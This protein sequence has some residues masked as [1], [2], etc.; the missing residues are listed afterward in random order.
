MT[1]LALISAHRV[2][3]LHK[4]KINNIESLPSQIN[5]KIPDLIKTSKAGINQPMLCIPFFSEKPEICPA[6]TLLCYI[7]RT[8]PLRKTDNLLISFK[9]PHNIITT[10]SI[11]RWIKATLKDCGIDDS[12]FTAHNTRHASTSKAHQL[13]VN[14][15]VIRKTAGW[16]GTSATFGKFY[17]R[18]IINND[19]QITLA[20]AILNNN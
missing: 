2:Q 10:Q 18:T 6:T 5:I 17:H 19:D 12:I 13:G 11:S 9:K 15:D 7:N 4:I 14:I 20:R 3:T 1:L 16:S 8:A